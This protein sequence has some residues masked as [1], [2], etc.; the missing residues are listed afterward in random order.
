MS[1]EKGGRF[2]RL[3]SQLVPDMARDEW[4]RE[5]TGEIDRVAEAPGR[6]DSWTYFRLYAAA[7]EDALRLF[8]SGL[9]TGSVQGDLRYALRSLRMNPGYT[10]V[11]VLTL[12]I[13]IGA[14]AA[15]YS[16][17]DSY[18]LRQ[19]PLEQ[20]DRLVSLSEAKDG[21]I[22]QTSAP[23]FV[24]WRKQ[25]V[26]F[27]DMAGIHLSSMTLT[28]QGAPSRLTVA[29]VT[30]GFFGLLG[31]GQT[32]GRGFVGEEGIEGQHRA[33]VLSHSLWASAFGSDPG[34]AGRMVTLSGERY[35][36]VGVAASELRVPP[37]T[38]DLYVPLAF[39]PDALDS[40][41]RNNVFVIG[42]LADGA[43]LESARTEMDGIAEALSEAYPLSNE[44]WGIRATELHEFAVGSSS[45]GLWMLLGSVVLVLLIACVNVANLTI[46][47]GVARGRELA[48]RVAVGASQGRL[49]RQ[50]LI[51]TGVLSLLGCLLGI[52]VA[53]ALLNP[54][55]SLVPAR[56]ARLGD[57]SMDSGVLLFALGI[58]LATAL[59]SGLTPAYRM[60]RTAS[61]GQGRSNTSGHLTDRGGSRRLRGGLVVSEFA[62]AMMLLVGAGLFLRTLSEL[63]E[64][65]LGVAHEG[66]TTFAVTFSDADYRE[67]EDVIL[68]VDRL[69]AELE[70][71]S[72]IVSVAAT[73][74]LPLS[75]SRLTSSLIIEGG[76]QEHGVNAP[77]AA[78]KVVTP[79]YF[80][81]MGIPLLAGRSLSREDEEGSELVVVL[82]RTA[83]SQYWPGEDAVGKWISYTDDEAEQAIRR[84][85]V[86][87]IGD[88]HYAGPSVAP[89]PEVYQS[90]VQTT[91][92]WRWFGRTM[93]YVARTR[94]GQVLG[95]QRVQE[96]MA[97]VDPRVP[98]VGLGPLT[99]VLDRS[100][101]APRFQG[102]LIG[103]FAGLALL[104]AVVG[105]YGVMSF[106][107]RQQTREIGIRV[108]MGARRSSVLGYVLWRGL[109]LALAGTVLGAIGAVLLGRW[110]SSLLWG[111]AST[112]PLTYV[113]VAT[114]LAA[115]TV[116]ATLV[117]ALRASRV[118]PMVA[119]RSE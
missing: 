47:R 30:P 68:G 9:R 27:D 92:V 74:H 14:N 70:A 31:S 11:A 58:S 16:V 83:A 97:T 67:P 7:T 12:A 85:V 38:S 61:R 1:A 93:S 51:E 90:H 10:A 111:V 60:S 72:D 78:I 2:L 64:V 62:L 48:V 44:G 76:P 66:I 36:V 119:L 103:L 107:V 22:F 49:M 99:E 110:V 6:R 56:L 41:G 43:S 15:I 109:R 96:M 4:K 82:N 65:D 112:D 100:V 95:L 75:G 5:W 98:V 34:V 40:R 46:A 81:T 114:V 116:V 18:V 79:G 8:V 87:V 50:L 26:R 29:Q 108:A 102:T 89:I 101:A 33:V 106:S 24:D 57:L 13:G 77:S 117:P 21:R 19:L 59:L 39:T 45:T 17:V 84:R 23:N 113:A 80:S 25:S 115:S 35:E 94:N 104:L 53:Y 37:F 54:I 86:G 42:R 73:S 28:G 52:G 32:L 71:R 105:T 3:L 20:P 118:D 91:E 69:F 88:V 55:A 63:Y